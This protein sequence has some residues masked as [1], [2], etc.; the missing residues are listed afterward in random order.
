MNVLS[1]YGV[2]GGAGLAG[3]YFQSHF[4]GITGNDDILGDRPGHPVVGRSGVGADAGARKRSSGA[5]LS[6]SGGHGYTPVSAPSVLPTGS[7]FTND[8]ITNWIQ[9]LIDQGVIPD[10]S[11]PTSL[12]T[13]VLMI[14]LDDTIELV[15]RGFLGGKSPI[16][17]CEDASDTAYGYHW[18][19]NTRSGNPMYYAVIPSLNDNCIRKGGSLDSSLSQEQ[20]LTQVASHEFAEMCTDPQ[21]FTGWNPEIGDPCNGDS[22]TITVGQNIWT[23]QKIYSLANDDGYGEADPC[24]GSVPQHLPANSN[25]PQ[26]L[27][28]ALAQYRPG[29]LD[30]LLP[31]PPVCVSARDGSAEVNAKDMRSYVS[32]LTH[33]L[34]H[35][36]LPLGVPGILR[37][38]AD[39]IE[40]RNKPARSS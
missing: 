6:G 38:A 22:D 24:V 3:A 26:L 37:Q 25:G 5:V 13:V 16:V 12:G 34:R 31:L 28:S 19:F 20:R 7:D 32:R 39:I 18:F 36:D 8:T 23:V 35:A 40:T 1:Q 29:H 10:A 27:A 17:M 2:G 11:D 15:D 30:R 9:R 21:P 4:L 14:F 33:P